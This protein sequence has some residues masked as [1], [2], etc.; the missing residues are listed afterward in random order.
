MLLL[1][2]SFEEALR[3]E[4]APH[5]RHPRPGRPHLGPLR[6]VV[7]PRPRVEV[8]Q[9]LVEHQ[10]EL[11][12]ELEDVPVRVAVVGEEVVAGPVPAGAPHERI[13]VPREVVARELDVRPVA[14]LPADVMQPAIVLRAKQVQRVMVGVAAEEHEEV[15]HPVRPLE[16]EPLV[17]LGRLL[18]VPDEVADVAELLRTDGARAE[19]AAELGVG[20]ELQP[21]PVGILDLEELGDARLGVAPPLG[22]DAGGRELRLRVLDRPRNPER[23]VVEARR[24]AGQ[25]GDCVVDDPRGEVDCAAF[26]CRDLEAEDVLVVGGE[27]LDVGRGEG[28]MPDRDDVDHAGAP[29]GAS[30]PSRAAIRVSSTPS[31]SISTR[32]SSPALR[33]SGGLRPAPTPDGV[34]VAITSPGSSAITLARCSITWATVKI[35]SLVFESCLTCPFT[36]SEISSVCGSETKLAGVIQGPIGADSLNPFAIVQLGPRGVSAVNQSRAEMS[37]STL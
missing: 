22:G 30:D 14:Q 18:D 34:P 15:A 5:V 26:A 29:S 33:N 25:E 20:V 2:R 27:A 6:K 24:V 36:A 11:G 16:A 4:R 8:A 7:M 37:L 3:R 19:L 23:E 21:V 10:V 32:I 12:E 28:E 1:P 13:V 9:A 31:P 17:E 35:I